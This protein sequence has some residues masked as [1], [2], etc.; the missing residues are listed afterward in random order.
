MINAESYTLYASAP[1]LPKSIVPSCD[2]LYT[3]RARCGSVLGPEVHAAVLAT[4]VRND[5][6]DRGVADVADDEHGG[7]RRRTDGAEV[8]R[9]REH[10]PAVV[11]G[12]EAGATVRLCYAM[13]SSQ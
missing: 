4:V 7:G 2:G 9:E 13:G 1:L 6:L 8:V 12:A 11:D 3:H 5:V 10:G